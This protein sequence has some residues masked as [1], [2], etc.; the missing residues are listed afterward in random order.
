MTALMT[1]T[2]PLQQFFFKQTKQSAHESTMSNNE[3]IKKLFSHILQ[4]CHTLSFPVQND[5][6][7]KRAHADVSQ[8]NISLLDL[9]QKFKMTQVNYSD[10]FGNIQQKHKITKVFQFLS[11]IRDRLLDKTQGPAY[12]G[13][14]SGPII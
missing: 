8:E 10:L 3:R 14:S 5:N 6:R 7:F 2:I 1:P 9:D 11:R 12:H 13:N 4:Q